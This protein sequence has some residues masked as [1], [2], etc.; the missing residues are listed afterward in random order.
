MS[1]TKGDVA[2]FLLEEFE[3]ST[4]MFRIDDKSVVTN[5]IPLV[6]YEEF[7]SYNPST[8]TFEIS[9]SGIAKVESLNHSVHGIAFGVVANDEL[10]YTGYFWPAYSS[11][12]C[13]WITI[14]PLAIEFSGKG[15]VTLGYPG[16]PPGVSIPDK[17]ND[18]RILEIFKRDGKLTE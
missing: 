5:S 2:V 1:I 8:Y 11:M 13:D 7:L 18:R 9:E 4:G 16:V 3:I 15:Q 17:R 12:S 6:D 14:D 10:V